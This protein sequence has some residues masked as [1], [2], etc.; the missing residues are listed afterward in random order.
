MSTPR[1]KSYSV[2]EDDAA[3]KS[4]SALVSTHQGN[5]QGGPTATPLS[6]PG[7]VLGHTKMRGEMRTRLMNKFNSIESVKQAQT[8][9]TRPPSIQT[10]VITN[11]PWACITTG[12]V[13]SGLSLLPPA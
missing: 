13:T 11:G 7:K 5:Q 4:Y 6:A 1:T 9:Y 8:A 2:G 3:L 10:E 12:C